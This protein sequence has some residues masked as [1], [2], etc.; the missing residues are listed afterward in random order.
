MA[1][2]RLKVFSKADRMDVEADKE[3]LRE[4]SD[5]RGESLSF[6]VSCVAKALAMRDVKLR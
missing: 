1:E 2:G 5:S 4:E 3:V 6:H